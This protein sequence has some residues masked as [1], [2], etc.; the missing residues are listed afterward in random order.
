MDIR[1]VKQTLFAW[2]GVSRDTSVKDGVTTF[3]GFRGTIVIDE[4]GG[5][6]ELRIY[7]NDKLQACYIIDNIVK[8]EKVLTVADNLEYTLLNVHYITYMGTVKVNSHL[9]AV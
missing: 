4:N 3:K 5:C 8:L 9:I 6:P 7:N 1:L 2:V